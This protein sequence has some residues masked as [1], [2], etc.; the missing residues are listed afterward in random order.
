MSMIS[1]F[2]ITIPIF[3]PAAALSGE[4]G[5]DQAKRLTMEMIAWNR[6]NTGF[7]LTLLLN[8]LLHDNY[9]IVVGNF[10][11]EFYPMG[12]RSVVVVDLELIKRLKDR[13]RQFAVQSTLTSDVW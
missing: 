12:I 10:V 7:T 9:K 4:M 3:A 5:L 11:E 2:P 1:I 8:Y 6:E 13:L